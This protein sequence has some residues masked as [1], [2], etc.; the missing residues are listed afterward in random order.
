MVTLDLVSLAVALARPSPPRCTRV[1]GTVIMSTS[2]PSQ[3]KEEVRERLWQDGISAPPASTFDYSRCTWSQHTHQDTSAKGH[4]GRYRDIRANLDTDYHGIYS[5][6]RAALQDKL[7]DDA[8]QGVEGGRAEPWCVFTAGAMGAGK[9]HTFEH[10]VSDGVVP[11][12]GVQILDP[13]MFKASL[14]EW[15]G[16]LRRDPLMAGFHT[17][18]ESGYLLEIAQE[19]ALQ[20]RRHVWVDG[21]LRCASPSRCRAAE[22]LPRRHAAAAPSMGSARVRLRLAA[23]QG[24]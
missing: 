1:G 24:R 13:D 8:L 6:S 11:L 19:R 14:P 16:Y 5:S 9:S 12:Q 20:E 23:P 7:I 22:P 21:S 15:S 3:A 2:R 4:V 18:R 17:R 10:L